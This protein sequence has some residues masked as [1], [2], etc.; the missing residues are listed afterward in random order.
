[1]M[2]IDTSILVPIFR[3]RS[4][5]RRDRFR[6]FLGGSNYM[7]SR[8]TQIELLQGCASEP[9]WQMLCHYLEGQDYAELRSE[10][11]ADAARIHFDLRR[12]GLSVRSIL[13]CCIAQVA[14]DA[15]LTLVHNDVD[16]EAIGKVRPLR[17]RRLEIQ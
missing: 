4:G 2:L 13:D 14:L 7:I 17:A 6:Q 11:W 15:R 12:M 10:G 3:D 1:M 8:F 9:Q 5:R 16:F